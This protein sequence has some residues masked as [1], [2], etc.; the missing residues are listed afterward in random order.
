MGPSTDDDHILTWGIG[1]EIPVWFGKPSEE[2][3]ALAM[4]NPLLSDTD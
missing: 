4:K 1:L 2:H 3:V